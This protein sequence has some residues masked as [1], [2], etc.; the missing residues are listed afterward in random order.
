MKKKN[1]FEKKLPDIGKTVKAILKKKGLT[2]T[3]LAKKAEWQ[4]PTMT[5]LLNR[6]NWEIAELLLIGSILELDLLDYYRAA[7]TEP[8]LPANQVQQGLDRIQKLEDT[9]A[10]LQ[11]E[12]KLLEAKYDGALEA[13]DKLRK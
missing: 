5:L 1:S 12:H 4:P 10:K 8:M 6:R 13:M 9:I 2:Q 3:A 7:P 11:M